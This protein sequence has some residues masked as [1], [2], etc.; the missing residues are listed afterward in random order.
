MCNGYNDCGDM[1]DESQCFPHGYGGF[2]GPGDIGGNY[3]LQPYNPQQIPSQ[4][5]CDANTQ[6]TCYRPPHPYNP[7]ARVVE[8]CI[9]K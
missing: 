8:K 7:T 9:P 3:G 1:S 5:S 6:F 4:V 2:G